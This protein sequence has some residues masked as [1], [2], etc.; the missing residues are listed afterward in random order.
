VEDSDYYRW[1]SSLEA[2]Q[3]SSIVSIASPAGVD[4]A[5][6]LVSEGI[7]LVYREGGVRVSVNFYNTPAEVELL[8]EFLE[9][10]RSGV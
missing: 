5:K 10:F 3:R 9:R 7:Y 8:I 4:L 2:E 6:Y 1:R